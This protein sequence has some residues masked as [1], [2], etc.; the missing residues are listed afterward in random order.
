[1]AA[2]VLALCAAAI[3]DRETCEKSAVLLRDLPEPERRAIGPIGL[4]YLALNEGR[5][6]DALAIYER[7]HAILPVGRGL[8]RWEPEWAEAMIRARQP[9]GRVEL[10]VGE[11]EAV[12]ADGPPAGPTASVARRACSPTTTTRRREPLRPHRPGGRPRSATSSAR[13]APRSCGASGCAGPV[14]G[15]R[16]GPTSSGPSSCCAASARRVLAERATTELRAAGGVVGDDRGV[17]P[18]ADPARAA[19][20]PARRQRG[21]EPGPRRQ[22][23]HQPADRRGP[24][25]G[26][27]PQARRAQPPRAQRRAPSTT[28]SSSRDDRAR[29]SAASCSRTSSKPA[30]VEATRE[31]VRRHVVRVRRLSGRSRSVRAPSRWCRRARRAAGVR[32]AGPPHPAPR[33]GGDEDGAA[34]HGLGRPVRERVRL[35]ESLEVGARAP[36]ATTARRSASSAP[37]SGAATS[38]SRPSSSTCRPPTPRASGRRPIAAPVP[39]TAPLHQ[40]IRF[41]TAPDGA[42]I[43]YATMGEGPVLVKAANWLTHLDHDRETFVWRHW[44]EGLAHRPHAGALRRAGLR[45]VGLGRRELRRS[46]TGSTTSSWS[47]TPPGSTRSRCSACRRARRWRSRSPPATPSG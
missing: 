20:R 11:L 41:C 36:S 44:L 23:V 12:A 28:P 2:G 13:D 42:R 47:S 4:G 34:G 46:T 45:H 26:H 31:Y 6:D 40:S 32:R 25:H 27:L 17:A 19:G 39:P 35:G 1:M 29:D 24:P 16:P 8:V 15:P 10:L 7:V 38:S 5:V 18:A 3:G 30:G 9:D 14:G 43:A 21:V 33:P 37:S 22:A